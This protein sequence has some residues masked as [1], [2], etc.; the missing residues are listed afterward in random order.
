MTTDHESLKCLF[1]Y[2]DVIV[3]MRN[4]IDEPYFGETN[5]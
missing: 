2:S 4:T 3:V 5:D 1:I